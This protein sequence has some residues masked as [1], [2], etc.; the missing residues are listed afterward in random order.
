MTTHSNVC[1]ISGKES[2]QDADGNW[3]SN[4]GFPLQMRAIASLFDRMTLLV[5]ARTTPG[6]GGIRL[7]ENAEVVVLRTPSGEDF[8]RKISVLLHLPHLFG[9]MLRHARNADVV[10]VPPPGDIP[11]LG[12]VAALALRKRL[13]ARYCGSWFATNRTTLANRMTRGLMRAFAGGRNV[14]L[15]TGESECPPGRGIH[16]IFSTALTATELRRP[17]NCERGLSNPPRL[18]YVGR[19]HAEKGV[20]NLIE[21]IAQLQRGGF[22]PM[23]RLKI[24]GN[25][26]ER[27][28]LA[29]RVREYQLGE[30]IQFTGQLDR[31]ALARE[32]EDLDVAV[33]PSLTEGFSKAWLDALSMGA[34]VLGSEAGAARHVLGRDG[35]RGWLVKPGDIEGLARTLKRVLSE[36]R[37]WPALRRR[38]RAYAESRTLE[39]WAE[40]IGR[41]CANQWNVPF[42]NG[43]LGVGG[44]GT[45]AEPVFVST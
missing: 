19:L 39:S 36:P 17:P 6:E 16:W 14:M 9:T 27:D 15:A 29:A 44:L 33:Q 31:D 40:A 32:L 25:G 5:T 38:C 21:A 4:G 24:I 1:V 18:A 43:K 41:I 42:A 28:M 35:E 45:M 22:F 13:I 34:P 26:P 37:D 11:L 23:P 8:R 12:M 2:W 20:A 10:H 30:W 7:P 3:Y